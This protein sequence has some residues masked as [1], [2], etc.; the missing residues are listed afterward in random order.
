MVGAL[1]AIIEVGAMSGSIDSR[2]LP[3]SR[4]PVAL[5]LATA[6]LSLVG[7]RG[8][9]HAHEAAVSGAVTVAGPTAPGVAAP[10]PTAEEN[11]IPPN[12][13]GP[14]MA[15]SGGGYCYGGPHPAPGGGWEAIA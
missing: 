4:L 7:L 15:A 6:A 8:V 3:S 13:E 14:A 9:A 11:L 2:V 12:V 5:A 10:A 1:L